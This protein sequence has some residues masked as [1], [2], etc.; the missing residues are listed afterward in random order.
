MK[1]LVIVYSA[2]LM[3][4]ILLTGCKEETPQKIIA[5]SQEEGISKIVIQIK[6]GEKFLISLDSNPTTGYSWQL[7]KPL[8][9]K[10]IRLVSSKYK[11]PKTELVGVGG[12]E[13]WTFK[14]L[15]RGKTKIIFVYARPWEKGI[16][17]AEEKAVDIIVE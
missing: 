4:A 2:F 16:P 5:L 9:E 15:G 1:R 8:D 14:A 12:R 3:A 11:A 13:S 6:K 7:A 10:I 17:P